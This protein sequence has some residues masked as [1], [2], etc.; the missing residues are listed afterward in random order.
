MPK[1]LPFP[2]R[3]VREVAAYALALSARLERSN[4]TRP[5]RPPSTPE[6]LG[7]L[8]QRLIDKRPSIVLALESIVAEML[9]QL[10]P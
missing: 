4:K 2:S 7:N 8:L 10:D 1:V 6:R 5:A 3:R 9:A